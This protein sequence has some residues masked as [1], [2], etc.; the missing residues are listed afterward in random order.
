MPRPREEPCIAPLVP[1]WR[2]GLSFLAQR[3]DSNNPVARWRTLVRERRRLDRLLR[4]A[5]D[6]PRPFEL[7][8]VVAGDSLL[9]VGEFL[10]LFPGNDNLILVP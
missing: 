1:H 5:D 8:N 7:V 4:E 10:S 2:G 6:V 9:R 3:I